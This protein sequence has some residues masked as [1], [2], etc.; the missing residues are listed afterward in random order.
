VGFVPVGI[1]ENSDLPQEARERLAATIAA[2]P[3]G[4]TGQVQ[5]K[6]SDDDWDFGW[7]DEAGGPN[8]STTARGSVELATDAEAV[9]GTDA[10]RAV[11]PHA[12]AAA[13]V[14]SRGKYTALNAQTGTTYTPALTD[15][16]KFV[17]LDNTSGI[18]V[19]LPQDSDV[20][21]PIGSRVDFIGINTGLVTFAAGTG[22]TVNGTPSLVSRARWSAVTAVKRAAN[23]WVV[24]GDLA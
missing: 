7:V 16:G 3:G 12:L 5:K 8:A 1:D 22:A 21:F 11:T 2:R 13:I 4:T 23:T 19:T 9:T 15:I 24:I 14:D 20:A 10:E 17:T 18:T 6:L